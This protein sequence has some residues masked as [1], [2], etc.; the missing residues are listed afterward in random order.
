MGEKRLF[1]VIN[2]K[3][4]GRNVSVI[5]K[6]W[7]EA[8]R[9][10][11]A[12]EPT[13]VIDEYWTQF[14][15]DVPSRAAVFAPGVP[16][17][18]LC[19]GGDGTFHLVANRLYGTEVPAGIIPLG[20]GNGLASSLGFSNMREAA[21]RIGLLV[22][23]SSTRQELCERSK[24]LDAIQYELRTAPPK[25][26]AGM[27]G[28]PRDRRCCGWLL[29]RHLKRAFGSKDAGSGTSPE[30]NEQNADDESVS[31]DTTR[32]TSLSSLSD[33]WNGYGFLSLSIGL[34]ADIDI[35]TECMRCI[36]DF[37]F[38]LGSVWY[39][40]RKRSFSALVEYRHVIPDTQSDTGWRPADELTETIPLRDYVLILAMNVSHASPK[41][42][43]APLARAHDGCMD[44]IMV[45]ASISRFRLIHYMLR[46]ESGEHIHDP[47]CRYFK[48]S[49]IRIQLDPPQLVSLDGE[50]RYRVRSVVLE[51]GGDHIPVIASDRA[52]F[53]AES[54]D[55]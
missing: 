46:L 42:R 31:S 5:K 50:A 15:G 55:P 41:A 25:R 27:N 32:S 11:L 29:P 48:C 44:V 54:L 49:W 10:L 2:S 39:I 1:V 8:K 33:R 53:S 23:Q 37:R 40:L 28:S 9:S 6:Q 43:F 14:P 51:Q 12:A 17:A 7:A 22:C 3:C 13:L 35:R 30:T 21:Q 20:T 16:L 4:G 52:P 47:H 24:R 34:V 38:D 18:V 19:V 45:P 26:R 36:G